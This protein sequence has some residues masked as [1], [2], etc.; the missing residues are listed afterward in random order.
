L[1]TTPK[2]PIE[3]QDCPEIGLDEDTLEN[4]TLDDE[5]AS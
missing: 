5:D 1:I 2:A 4:I 3:P